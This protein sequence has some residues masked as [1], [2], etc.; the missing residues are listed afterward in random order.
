[1]QDVGDERVPVTIIILISV[2][3]CLTV[4]DEI[5]KTTKIRRLRNYG[6]KIRSDP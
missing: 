3:E 4:T 5:D 2:V 6:R 1:M